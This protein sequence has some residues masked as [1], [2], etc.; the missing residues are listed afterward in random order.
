MLESSNLGIPNQYIA[1]VPVKLINDGRTVLKIWKNLAAS[2]EPFGCKQVLCDVM[3]FSNEPIERRDDTQDEDPDHKSMIGGRTILPSVDHSSSS[4]IHAKKYIIFCSQYVEGTFVSE[5]FSCTTVAVIYGDGRVF[6]SSVVVNVNDMSDIDL[7]LRGG[8]VTPISVFSLSFAGARDSRPQVR[9]LI[10][11]ALSRNPNP[12]SVLI[13]PGGSILAQRS[14]VPDEIVRSIWNTRTWY[15]KTWLRFDLVPTDETYAGAS[16][17]GFVSVF[18][19]MV[20]E[21]SKTPDKAEGHWHPASD[22]E[23]Q[24]YQEA[25]LARLTKEIASF[26][27]PVPDGDGEEICKAGIEKEEFVTSMQAARERKN[28]QKNLKK[29]SN[30]NP[31]SETRCR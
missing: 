20:V 2:E 15:E 13:L 3:Y 11:A 10:Q 31:K 12:Y 1:L 16:G 24:A 30:V 19:S 28:T 26:C 25:I 4:N 7:D 17:P 23:S 21:H 27:K 6:L 14:Y 29:K 18:F 8:D 5:R 9:S 22:Q